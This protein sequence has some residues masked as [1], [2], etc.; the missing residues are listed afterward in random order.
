MTK[1]EANK[2]LG[3]KDS[4][5]RR[6][7]RVGMRVRLV[8]GPWREYDRGGAPIKEKGRHDHEFYLAGNVPVG[9]CGTVIRA[10]VYDCDNRPTKREMWAIDY[11]GITPKPFRCFGLCGPF[12]PY[13]FE[14][15]ES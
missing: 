5:P 4:T 10:Q 13:N 12:L 7:L 3:I 9:T 1:E 14:E 11:D 6:A 8:R 2:I 15:V